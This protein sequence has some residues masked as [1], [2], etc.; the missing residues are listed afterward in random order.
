MP[1]EEGRGAVLLGIVEGNALLQVCSGRGQTLPARTR[2][3]LAHGEPPE[4][5]RVLDALGQAEKLL[6][7][8]PRRL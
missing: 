1:I 6:S 8:L 7:Q 3:S 2:C 4:E 5:R